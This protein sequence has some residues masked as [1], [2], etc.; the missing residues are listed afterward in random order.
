MILKQLCKT[1]AIHLTSTEMDWKKVIDTNHLFQFCTFSDAVFVEWVISKYK[2]PFRC[3]KIAFE[4][5]DFGLI[6]A[7]WC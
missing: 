5:Y 3:I 6:R 1:E 7:T 2:V 4:L